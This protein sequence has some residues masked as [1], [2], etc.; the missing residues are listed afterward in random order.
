M[1]VITDL[2][3]ENFDLVVDLH[4]NF[5][6]LRVKK[7]L[8]R[9]SAS[10][11]K[12][13]RQ[14]WLMVNL[15]INTLPD[16]HIVDRYF[17]AVRSLGVI[18]DLKGL[19]YFIDEKDKIEQETLPAEFHNGY[20]A[21]VIGGKHKTK[22]FPGEKIISLCKKIKTP[23]ILLG[24]PDDKELG[25]EVVNSGVTGV[26]NA[27]GKYNINQSAS[28]VENAK[29][30]ITNDTGLMHIAAAFEK[31]IVSIWGNTI[32]EFGM[33]PYLT[34]VE[35]DHCMIA[36]VKGLKCRPCSKIGYSRCPR[37]HFRCMLDIDEEAIL[38]F[39]EK[40]IRK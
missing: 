31:P 4:K 20:I 13:N 30:V 11:N 3:K 18:N 27:C 10:F 38:E 33:Y 29:V 5:R 39:L 24:G 28:I 35:A 34:A 19:D 36:E 7:A 6:T 37:K 8:K 23:V 1:D 22:I 14:K 26:L 40:T 17:E 15:K 25:D 2:K 12:L 32:P 21:F 16:V 9:P